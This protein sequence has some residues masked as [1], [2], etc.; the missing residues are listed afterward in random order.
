MSV[1]GSLLGVDPAALSLLLP[2]PAAPG[3]H[4]Q[5][6]REA[7]W[8]RQVFPPLEQ[9]FLLGRAS[10]CFET[11]ARAEVLGQRPSPAP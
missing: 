2:S 11:D 9:A 7:G 3:G 1:C 4:G 8:G 6:Q 10:L 5:H